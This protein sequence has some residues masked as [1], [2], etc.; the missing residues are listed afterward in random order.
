MRFSE[1]IIRGLRRYPRVYEF[2]YGWH[3]DASYPRCFEET[4]SIFIHIPKCAGISMAYGLYGEQVQ[5]NTWRYWRR[6]NPYRYEKYFK[7]SVIREPEERFRSAFNYLKAGGMHEED[8]RMAEEFLREF[9]SPEALADSNANE[10]VCRSC[11]HFLPQIDY[12]ASKNGELQVD[13]VVPLAYLTHGW[14]IICDRLGISGDRDLPHLNSR[15][16]DGAKGSVRGT[17]EGT[18]RDKLYPVYGGDYELYSDVV[19]RYVREFG[20]ELDPSPG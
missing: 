15:K 18:L 20:P 12:I 14:K 7:F 3:P 13:F 2:A 10:E 8:R 1:T 16:R 11:L 17:L 6:I 19:D 9:D 5:H 4:E